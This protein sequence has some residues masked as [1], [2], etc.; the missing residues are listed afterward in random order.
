MYDV[1]CF[2]SM[3]AGRAQGIS[4]ICMTTTDVNDGVPTSFVIRPSHRWKTSDKSE[5]HEPHPGD[6]PL[7]PVRQGAEFAA[8]LSRWVTRHREWGIARGRYL[9]CLRK[10]N[11]YGPE[12]LVAAANVFDILPSDAGPPRSELSEELEATRAMCVKMFRE[13]P[14]GIDRNSALSTLG[15]FGQASLPKKV[16]YRASIVQSTLGKRYSQL[17]FVA[18]VAVKVRNFFVHGSADGVDFS[19]VEHLVPFLTDTLEF[20]FAASDFIEAGWDARQ[21]D[22]KPHG[23]GHTFSRYRSEFDANLAELLRATAD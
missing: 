4:H 2:L 11:V 20:V 10:G 8:V 3:A 9:G 15:R 21:W 14:P 12:R 17:P 7:D 5:Q 18:K 6:V 13:L 22:A 1:A 16:D 19:K 23:W